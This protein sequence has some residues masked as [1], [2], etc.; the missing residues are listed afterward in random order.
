MYL[1][2][3]IIKKNKLKSRNLRIRR[4]SSWIMIHIFNGSLTN[5][6]SQ[7]H[8]FATK[9]ILFSNR[10]LCRRS[11]SV[12]D[13]IRCR[14]STS[15]FFVQMWYFLPTSIDAR[16]LPV[17]HDNLFIKKSLKKNEHPKRTPKLLSI[18]SIDCTSLSFNKSF[19]MVKSKRQSKADNP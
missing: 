15:R 1:L 11:L 14:R 12:I 4:I 6:T 5:K 10:F 3:S 2:R 17:F 7:D 13:G 16:P 18:F 8:M 9:M 19:I